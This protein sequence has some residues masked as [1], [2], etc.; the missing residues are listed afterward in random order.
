MRK[1]ILAGSL[2]ALF[3]PA[4]AVAQSSLDGTWKFDLKTAQLPAKPSVFVLQDGVYTC[5][6]CIPPIEV[7]ADGEDHKVTG[8]PY[9]D[10]VRIKILDDNTIEETDKKAG[11]TV[12]VAKTTVS[13][14]GKTAVTEFTDSSNTNAAPVTGKVTATRVA[15][16]PAGSHAVSGSWRTSKVSSLS[17]NAVLVTFKV[18]GDS[19]QMT[20]LTGQ[21]YTAKL[22]GTEAPYMGDPGITTVFVKRIDANT[23]EETDKRKGKVISVARM[24][25]SPDGK[26]MKLSVH[27]MLQG[28]TTRVSAAKQ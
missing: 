8:H 21:S 15:D 22:D 9:Y 19:L 7:K 6:T 5:K 3:V 20:D 23:F 2:L 1:L 18:E 25:V 26:M 14:D 17:D 4:V 11:K 12:T 16:A 10:S 24:T 28:T 27:D 13:A